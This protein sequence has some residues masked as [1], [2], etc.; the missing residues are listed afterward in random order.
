MGIT[1]RGIA[2][3]TLSRAEFDLLGMIDRRYFAESSEARFGEWTSAFVTSHS[4]W[5]TRV[6]VYSRLAAVT[7]TGLAAVGGPV[8]GRRTRILVTGS[9][10]GSIAT[11]F[12]AA[13]LAER[14][15]LDNC[16]IELTD[17]LPE[18]LRLTRAGSFD[19]PA[20]AA[21]ATGV[22][23]LLSPMDYRQILARCEV[24]AADAADLAPAP[25]G[26]FDVVVSPYT[27]HH[28]NLLDKA[29]ACAELH[30]VTRPGGLV[31]IGD[32]TF[33]YEQFLDWLAHHREEGLPYA[34]ECFL[35][36]REHQAL[37]PGSKEVSVHEG[38]FFYAFA[39]VKA[40]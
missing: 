2:G 3:H 37:V 14:G 27:H 10:L 32:L 34:L 6:E 13:L 24:W 8:P 35:P 18:P 1:A 22:S 4:D 5:A 9:A 26:A 30:R 25:D 33:G 20:D 7:M 31:V 19:F 36:R 40:L 38:D 21:A 17:L 23:H 15:W 16:D 28:L 11:Y 12:H 29:R 39:M